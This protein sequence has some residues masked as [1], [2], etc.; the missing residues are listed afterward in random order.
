M[1]R[2]IQEEYLSDNTFYSIGNLD[3]RLKNP[4]QIITVDIAKFSNSLAE[5]F[6][7]LS[8]PVLDCIM[9]N[10]QLSKNVGGEALIGLTILVQASAVVRECFFSLSSYSSSHLPSTL[11]P[12]SASLTRYTSPCNI[13][14]FIFL[15]PITSPSHL[16]VQPSEQ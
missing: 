2:F 1:T 12:P 9:Y 15:S 6:G 11:I 16:P 10:I 5:L 7:S 14:F 4:D 3:D 8:K 13:F